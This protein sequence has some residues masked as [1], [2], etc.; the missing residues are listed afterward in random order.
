[1]GNGIA[2]ADERLDGLPRSSGPVYVD[3]QLFTK[4]AKLIAGRQLALDR[5]PGLKDLRPDVIQVR[6]QGECCEQ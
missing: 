2:I 3:L 1:M 5:L 4:K 6:L